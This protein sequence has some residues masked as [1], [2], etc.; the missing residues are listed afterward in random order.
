MGQRDIVWTRVS[1]EGYQKGLR[2][3][4]YGRILHAKLL[5]EYRKGNLNLE[6]IMAFTVCEDHERQLACYKVIASPLSFV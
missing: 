5:D 2:L 3:E 4:H 6:A 1:K